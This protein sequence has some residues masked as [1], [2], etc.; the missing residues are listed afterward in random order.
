MRA[1]STRIDRIITATRQIPISNGNT[2]RYVGPATTRINGILN[3]FAFEY[4]ISDQNH[5]RVTIELI[6]A[7]Y[8]QIQRTGIMPTKAEM[9]ILFPFELRSRPCNYT[10]AVF[11]VQQLL[12][13]DNRNQDS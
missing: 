5:K 7:M 3:E 8:E 11:I 4:E 1:L 9:F 13:D 10:V 12:L 6:N 2:Y